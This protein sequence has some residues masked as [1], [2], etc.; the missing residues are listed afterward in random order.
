MSLP[1]TPPE[2]PFTL[3]LAEVIALY[4]A[5]AIIASPAGI[6]HANSA[7]EVLLA[8]KT[9]WPQVHQWVL[10]PATPRIAIKTGEQIFEWQSTPLPGAAY[11]LLGRDATLEH[12]LT[13]ALADSRTR[14]KDLLDLSSDYVW[15][16]D[17]AGRFAFVAG[18]GLLGWSAEEVTGKRPHELGM[19]STDDLTTPFFTQIPVQDAQ[20]WIRDKNGEL[21]CLN[22]SAMPRFEK[23]GAWLGARGLCHDITD[24]MKAA[25]RLAGARLRERIIGHITRMI[26]DGLAEE[27]EFG[28]VVRAV[29]HA[30]SAE[31]AAIYRR[32][33]NKWELVA[34]YGQSLPSSAL[35]LCEATLN[36]GDA[37][38]LNSEG[39]EWLVCRT[40]YRRN[41]N[42]AVMIWREPSHEK[43]DDEEIRLIEAVAEQLGGV[44]AQLR[45]Q[46]E[47]QEKAERDGLT[48]LYNQRA[49]ADQVQERLARSG[50]AGAVLVNIDLDNFKTINDHLG[51]AVGDDVLKKV[52]AILESCIRGGDIAGRVGGDEFL[53]WLERTNEDGAKQVAQRVLT[54]IDKLAGTLATLPKKLGASIGI[55]PVHKG[56]SFASLIKRADATMY[57]AKHSGKGHAEM[58]S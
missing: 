29:T 4:A 57:K 8:D 2:L 5:P 56:E 39:H 28:A 3:P 7:A 22:I 36:R 54:N 32:D 24:Q 55:A 17:R 47:W 9:W 15:E 33:D 42:G 19:L 10:K 58:A 43:W 35:I 49:F 37:L 45:A 38:Q 18:K 40:Q 6:M 21:R 27:R 50:G 1:A 31:G 52:G 13:L 34:G 20:L 51:H 23:D 26:S 14:F 48:G 44:W 46:E 30:M 12:N 53:L 11:L 16:T 41:V 25:A